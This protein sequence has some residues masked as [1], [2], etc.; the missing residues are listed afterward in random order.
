M[1]AIPYT[2]ASQKLSE[3]MDRVCDDHETVIITRESQEAVV[4][5]SLA[6]YNSLNETAIYCV[7]RGILSGFWRRSKN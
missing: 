2:T 6:D 3:T 4:M 5:M 1:D 7:V